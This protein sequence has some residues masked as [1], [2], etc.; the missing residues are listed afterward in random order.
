M[1]GLKLEVQEAIGTVGTARELRVPWINWTTFAVM[2][3]HDQGNSQ[4]KGFI[5]AHS[6]K[7][8]GGQHS[9]GQ[10]A[11]ML[12]QKLR[13]HSNTLPT[14]RPHLLSLPRISHQ[15]GTQCSNSH[16]SGGLCPT[17]VSKISVGEL[18]ARIIYF[19]SWVSLS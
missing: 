15:L 17:A 10:Q 12:V 9:S 6:S 8:K 1:L 16:L 11:C 18:N 13:V 14:G 7:G 4:R 19:Y 2:K 3:H 5:W